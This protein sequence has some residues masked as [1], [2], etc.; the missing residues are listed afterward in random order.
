MVG[1]WHSSKKQRQRLDKKK[2]KK[3]EADSPEYFYT[4]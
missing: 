1:S 2:E 3:E 4:I